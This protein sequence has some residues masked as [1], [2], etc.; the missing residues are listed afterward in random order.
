MKRYRGTILRLTI[1]I[2][3][4]ALAAYQIDFRQMGRLLL[5]ASWVWVFAG[6]M[7]SNLSMVVR[8][9]RWQVLLEGAGAAGLRF[10]RL[11]ELYFVGNFFNAFLPSGFGGDVVRAVEVTRDIPA[12]VATGS[13]FLDRLTGLMALFAMG[14]A[15]FPFRP[16]DFPQALGLGVVL[17]S[18][19]GLAGGFL[20]LDGRLIRRLGR[21]P[22]AAR[23]PRALSPVGEGPLA[24]FFAAVDG[25][26]WPAIWKA[27][28][29]SAV[30]NL[31]LVGWWM[32]ATY[33]VN[34]P[35][36]Y[37]Y[38]LLIV[39]TLSVSQLVPTVGGLGVREMIAPTLY[40]GAGLSA[41]SA[42]SVSLLVFIMLRLTGFLGV[43]L[44]L[45]A[46]WRDQPAAS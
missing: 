7:L 25:C 34:Q 3:G 30:F 17:L 1:T 42:V 43:P 15:A 4:L 38:N 29:V 32:M 10:G 2:I 19:V 27:F 16:A 21:L 20:V 36:S 22:L 28:G 11:V 13:V 35:A 37:G 18:V 24:R 44:Y 9:Y 31:L 23:L 46:I 40:S 5:E 8:A 14:L 39:P 41:A 33:A 26:G 45:Y 12:D 6:F